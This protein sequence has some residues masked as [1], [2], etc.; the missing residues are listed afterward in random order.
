MSQS[1]KS[2]MHSKAH[3]PAS[4][5]GLL[6]GALPHD[7]PQPPQWLRSFA[8]SVSQPLVTLRSQ[9]PK[10]VLHDIIVHE[11]LM[12]PTMPLAAG[13]HALSQV[14]QLAASFWVSVHLPLQQSALRLLTTPQSSDITQVCFGTQV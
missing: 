13:S 7:M 2:L 12:Q 1:A 9:S 10:P 5:R 11:L 6:L 4:Q 8:M 14:P 3:L